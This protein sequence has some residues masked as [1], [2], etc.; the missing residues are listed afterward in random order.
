[1]SCTW[2]WG[3]EQVGR[4]QASLRLFSHLFSPLQTSKN[5]HCIT[6]CWLIQLCQYYPQMLCKYE[7]KHFQTKF[8]LY[9]N[10]HFAF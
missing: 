10:T 5:F 9:V 6:L 7:N 2:A 4:D 8:F 1:M 3:A